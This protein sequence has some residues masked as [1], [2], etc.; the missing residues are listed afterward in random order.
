MRTF[1]FALALLCTASTVIARNQQPG[2]NPNI[3]EKNGSAY[4]LF[5]KGSYHIL[6]SAYF[7]IYS[8]EQL[9]KGMKIGRPTTGY[10]F[11]TDADGTL[12]P[13]TIANLE[14]TF[15]HNQAFCYRLRTD[16]RSEKDLTTWLPTLKTYKIKY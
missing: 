4:R 8:H 15:A 12:Q 7:Y 9:V 6:D 14:K 1:T 13:L 10:Y 2:H 16:F 11:S 5:H 3:I